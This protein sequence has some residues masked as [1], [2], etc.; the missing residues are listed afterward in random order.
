MSLAKHPTL[1]N[2]K[3]HLYERV[4]KNNKVDRSGNVEI[5]LSNSKQETNN[6]KFKK[7]GS[8]RRNYSVDLDSNK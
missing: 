1:K 5:D 6:R 3:R 4:N 8:E 2:Y 7:I